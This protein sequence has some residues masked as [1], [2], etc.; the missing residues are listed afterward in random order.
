MAEVTARRFRLGSPAA[1]AVLFVLALALGAASLP[2]A[3][4]AGRGAGNNTP[5]DIPGRDTR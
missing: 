5:E 3:G 2:L 4:L 1:A